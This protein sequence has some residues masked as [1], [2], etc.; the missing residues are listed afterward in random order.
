MPIDR[1]TTHEVALSAFA[2]S[3]S[4][5]MDRSFTRFAPKRCRI[6]RPRRWRSLETITPQVARAGGHPGRGESDLFSDDRTA[7]DIPTGCREKR[8]RT[9]RP[10]RSR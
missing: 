8:T 10:R 7:L 6:R 4:D 5:R 1:D 9:Q 2:V 3:V